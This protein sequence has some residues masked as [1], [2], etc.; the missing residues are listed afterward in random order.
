MRVILVCVLLA[1]VMVVLPGCVT[2]TVTY[3]VPPAPPVQPPPAPEKDYYR[4]LPP[5]ADALRKITDPAQLPDF[6]PAFAADRAALLAALERSIAYFTYPSSR[7][8]YPVQGITHDRAQRSLA[9]FR[10]ILRAARSAEEF[11]QRIVEAF[12]VYQSIGCDDRGTVLFTGYYTPIFDARRK[13]D[14]EYRWPLYRQPPD[15]VKDGE[16][17]CLGRRTADGSIVPY[18]TRGQIEEG[19]LAG[20]ELVWLKDR[21]EAY[22]VTIQGS[23]K[24]RLEDGSLMNVGYAANNGYD[25]TSVALAMLK[26]GVIGKAQL[27]LSGLI[28][29]F[30]RRPELMS[31]YLPLNKRYVFFRE[32]DEE[33]RGSLGLA[34]TPYATLATDKD[35]FPRGCLTFVDTYIPS[36]DGGEQRPFKRFLL[37]QDTGGAIR[38]AG[39]ADIYIGVGDEAGRMAG[40]TYAEGKLYYLFLKEGPPPM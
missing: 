12:D 10:E 15:L 5:G 35:I 27:S 39:R 40:W 11:R 32:T 14:A 6:R 19:A 25:Y 8:Y 7:R 26:D 20:H 23:A 16:G 22:V 9:A 37:D 2:R 29:F 3:V 31:R 18:Y 38:A 30:K 1:A 34:V 4:P 24:L 33:P 21:F 17:R 36:A 13:P 28:E